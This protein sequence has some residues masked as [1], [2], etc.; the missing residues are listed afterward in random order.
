MYIIVKF[1]NSSMLLS[2]FQKNGRH[3]GVKWHAPFIK[4]DNM[5]VIQQLRIKSEY[6]SKPA[7]TPHSKI[8]HKKLILHCY[9]TLI[10][11]LRSPIN[12]TSSVKKPKNSYTK[13]HR[14]QRLQNCKYHQ[15][16]ATYNKCTKI[17]L[18]TSEQN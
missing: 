3:I 1:P 5:R 16:S 13:S 2:L 8:L 15:T 4:I 12:W 10:A 18:P 17:K 11:G 6:Q 9:N 14:Y 7:S